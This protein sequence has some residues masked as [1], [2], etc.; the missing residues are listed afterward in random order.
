M[1]K[2]GQVVPYKP[3]DELALASVS[4]VTPGLSSRGL[5]AANDYRGYWR[6]RPRPRKLP[7]TWPRSSCLR[8]RLV[9]RVFRICRATDASRLD[10]QTEL[11]RPAHARADD[12][13]RYQRPYFLNVAFQ[14][15]ASA[16][17]VSLA[18][19]ESPIT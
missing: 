16:S 5:V 13:G 14:S 11:K 9:A 1:H 12:A 3:A 7:R 10:P 2:R 17:S 19:P 8:R 4:V 18:V 15:A 6:S